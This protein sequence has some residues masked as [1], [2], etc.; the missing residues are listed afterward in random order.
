MIVNRGNLDQLL[1]GYKTLF[2]RGLE[3]APSFWQEIAMKV[4]SQTREENYS[5]LGQ[6]GAIREWMGPRVVNNLSASGYTIKNRDFEKTIG[7]PRNDV[8]D[9]QIGLFSPMFELMGYETKVFP[10][11]LIFSLLASGFATSCYDGQSFFDTDHPVG[12][13]GTTPVVSVSNMQAGS[14]TPWFLLDCS[15]PIRP[16]I[17]QMRKEFRFVAKD[18]ERDDNVFSNKEFVYGVDGRCNAG[19]GFWQLAFGSKDTLNTANYASAR[20]AMAS[21]KNDAGKVLGIRPTHLVVPPSLESA[22]LKLLNSELASG[23]ETNEWK[24]TA[25]LIVSPFLA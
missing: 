13:N 3:A 4:P 19:F 10:D 1:I 12:D 8:E 14:A 17:L 25:K 16:L 18:D 2:N 11:E 6:G 22:G 9:D 24:G 15:K 23:G 7:V 5:W 20:A 21:L